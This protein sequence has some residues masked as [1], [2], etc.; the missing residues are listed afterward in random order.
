VPPFDWGDAN[1]GAEALADALLADATG[2]RHPAA[3]IRELAAGPL[4]RLP[5]EG[6]VL[7]QEE[8]RRWSA[9]A[10]HRRDERKRSAPDGATGRG[11]GRPLRS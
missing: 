4:A 8:L 7:D 1:T 10:Q 11:R 5:R 9:R 6:F 2:S 3:E